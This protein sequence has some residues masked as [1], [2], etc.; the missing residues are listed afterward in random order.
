[1]EI[2]EIRYCIEYGKLVIFMVK[3]FQACYQQSQREK[4]ISPCQKP[5]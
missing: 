1:M 2:R 4:F 3:N 5:R